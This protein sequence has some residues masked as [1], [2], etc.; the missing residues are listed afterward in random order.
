MIMG[1]VNIEPK[2]CIVGNGGP[3]ISFQV[4]TKRVFTTAIGEQKRG[5]ER[6][7]VVAWGKLAE[8]CKQFFGKGHCIYTEGGLHSRIRESLEGQ[9]HYHIEIR[10]D[11]LLFL[12]RQVV[13]SL[14]KERQEDCIEET[15]PGQPP[16]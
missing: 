16:S 9:R 5:T 6:L 3:L 12:D 4:S 14:S 2:M 15:Q 13:P 1:N 11:R 10:A 8:Q 7:N